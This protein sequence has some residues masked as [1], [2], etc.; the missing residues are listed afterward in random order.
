[1]QFK[2]IWELLCF[3]VPRQKVGKEQWLAAFGSNVQRFFLFS[4]FFSTV[5]AFSFTFC[6]VRSFLFE[7]MLTIWFDLNW[8]VSSD[9]RCCCCW[10][11]CLLINASGDFGLS[12]VSIFFN[13]P[14]FTGQQVFSMF[15]VYFLVFSYTSRYPCTRRRQTDQCRHARVFHWPEYDHCLIHILL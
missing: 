2:S 4:T 3:S 10:F 11:S 9:D 5:I 8:I 6:L 13:R 12:P 15:V 1:M 7:K 14:W